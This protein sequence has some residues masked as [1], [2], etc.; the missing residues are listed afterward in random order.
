MARRLKLKFPD[1]EVNIGGQTGLD[2]GP[3]GSNKSQIL[4]VIAAPKVIAYRASILL[5]FS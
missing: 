4:R 2:L 1:L 3:K 5:I